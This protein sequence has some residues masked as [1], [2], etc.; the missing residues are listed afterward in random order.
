MP[1]VTMR[2]VLDE[3]IKGNYA[4]GAF[5]V[6]NMEQIKGIMEAARQTKSPVILQ[7]SR[8]ARKYAGRRFLR[9][10]IL[11]AVEEYPEIPI[12]MHLD[13]G[14]NL[15]SCV[16]A[17]EDG[18]TSVMIDGSLMEDGKTPS[19]YDYNLN[20]T[21]QVV[22]YAHERGVTVEGELGCLGGI[23]DGVGSGEM[24]LADPD[25]AVEFAKKTGVDALALGFGTSHG[26][27]KFKKEPKLA[28]YIVEKV[29]KS[30]P[31]LPIVS[32][33][34][35]SVPRDLVDR[36][37]AYGGHMPNA[38]G[39][40]LPDLVRSIEFGVRKINIDTDIRLG[41][42]GVIREVFA[43]EPDKFDLRDYLKPA[44]EEI[45]RIVA[46]RMRAFRTAGHAGDYAAK[47]LDE[48]KQLYAKN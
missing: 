17:I 37:N 10:L 41:V 33:G 14:N 43:K 8:G 36:I 18:F 28:Y 47:S 16:E 44:T 25:Q 13:H 11:A 48:V 27:Y 21:R 32:H 1:L 31:G 19:P 39:V 15:Q 22:L 23:E 46:E 5:N 12:A 3:A 7:A 6:N 40:P 30:L 34:S 45:T 26:A 2:Q 9:H 24:K 20:V 35:S 29:N 4:V 38:M 42:T